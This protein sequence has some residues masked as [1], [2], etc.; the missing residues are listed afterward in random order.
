MRVLH[1]SRRAHATCP[2]IGV[3]NHTHS[4][5]TLP[6]GLRSTSGAARPLAP[7]PCPVDAAGTRHSTARA[8]IGLTRIPTSIWPWRSWRSRSD[9]AT[10][11]AALAAR[12]RAVSA[13]NVLIA[14]PQDARPSQ[15][16][17]REQRPPAAARPTAAADS[18]ACVTDAS[19][20]ASVPR[21]SA[22]PAAPRHHWLRLC[23]QWQC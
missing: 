16:P 22:P 14:F 2:R 1:R 12:A 19:V 11:S 20:A 4:R 5:Q 13:N 3:R 7:A 15:P 8:R 23:R 17:P 21:S 6:I 9:M 18:S 10:S